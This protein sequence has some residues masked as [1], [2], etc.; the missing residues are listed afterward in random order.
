MK[1]RLGEINNIIDEIKENYKELKN[2]VKTSDSNIVSITKELNIC[3]S[4][5]NSNPQEIKHSP[6]KYVTST[7]NTPQPP[8]AFVQPPPP[9]PID[10]SKIPNVSTPSTSGRGDLLSQIQRG[11]KLKKTIVNDRSK[12]MVSKE[13]Q[14]STTSHYPTNPLIAAIAARANRGGSSM[15]NTRGTPQRK[16]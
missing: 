10:N 16:W 4:L 13:Q 15:K 9:P 11:K 12:P 1:T 8:Q 7:F 6:E 3:K 5:I 14:N 2:Q